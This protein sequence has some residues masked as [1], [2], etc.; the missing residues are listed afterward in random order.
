[1]KAK[2]SEARRAPAPS[3]AFALQRLAKKVSSRVLHKKS[4]AYR[5]RTRAHYLLDVMG[6]SD[7]KTRKPKSFIFKTLSYFQI[8]I[9]YSLS[10]Y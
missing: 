10:L 2:R 6:T 7:T 9:E 3:S 8:N 4:A 1:M 5:S